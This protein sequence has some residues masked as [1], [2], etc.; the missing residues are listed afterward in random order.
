MPPYPRSR[1]NRDA[2]N[3]HAA[4]DDVE[5]KFRIAEDTD[6]EDDGEAE[7]LFERRYQTEPSSDG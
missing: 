1:R 6:S 3:S 2:D 4:N 5:D 7:E